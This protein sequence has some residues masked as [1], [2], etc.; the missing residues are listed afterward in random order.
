MASI[1]EKATKTYL[2]RP[3]RSSSFNELASGDMCTVASGEI[4]SIL[5]KAQFHYYGKWFRLLFTLRSFIS[6]IELFSFISS[7]QEE[8]Q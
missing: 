8:Q 5:I 7:S 2:S 3:C 1:V 4:F 6:S